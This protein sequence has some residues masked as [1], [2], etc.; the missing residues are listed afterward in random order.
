MISF[1]LFSIFLYLLYLLFFGEKCLAIF[2]RACS[3][4][5]CGL[6]VNFVGFFFLALEHHK[7]GL[8]CTESSNRRQLFAGKAVR[9]WGTGTANGV[10]TLEIASRWQNVVFIGSKTSRCCSNTPSS[11]SYILSGQQN[12][13]LSITVG[14]N[15]KKKCP[16]KKVRT[17]KFAYTAAET[18]CVL[19]TFFFVLLW[20]SV[21]EVCTLK[22]FLF[23]TPC[24]WYFI[25]FRRKIKKKILQSKW[26]C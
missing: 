5:Y 8:H 26:K 14:S 7:S 3:V 10:F 23:S 20:L 11:V 17:K 2:W 9:E 22:G 25:F 6:K 19:S 15:P 12:A 24:R 18:G 13:S 4:Y 1:F 21:Q 16:R